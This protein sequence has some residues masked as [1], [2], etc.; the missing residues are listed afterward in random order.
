M[1]EKLRLMLPGVLLLQILFATSTRVNEIGKG[2]LGGTSSF[3]FK[4]ENVEG[5]KAAQKKDL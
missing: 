5:L 2:K 1:L 4:N 3:P